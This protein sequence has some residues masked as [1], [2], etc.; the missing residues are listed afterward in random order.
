[1]R[2]YTCPDIAI[3]EYKYRMEMHAHTKPAS[4]C[5]DKTP[6]EVVEIYKRCGYDAV[7][8]SNHFKANYTE[9][10][11]E[12]LQN[13]FRDAEIAAE[14]AGIKVLFA[15]E[16]TFYNT[17]GDYLVYGLHPEDMAELFDLL[18]RGFEHFAESDLRKKSIVFFAHPYRCTKKDA[19]DLHIPYMVDGVESINM[20]A[21]VN[22]DNGYATRRAYA[23]NLLTICGS[24]Y[25]HEG[26]HAMSALLVKKVPDTVE[27]LRDLLR[28]GDY[29]FE[30]NG[31]IIIP[32][33]RMIRNEQ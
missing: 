32:S 12:L 26:H 25:H 10:S 24:D 29:L 13:D 22:S 5:G 8:I 31:N 18:P 6:A 1:M 4:P 17:Y 19:I 30:V 27:E 20:H 2:P 14:K 11:I 28:S 9:E 33:H 15:V 7:V 21:E 23:E 3:N 16:L